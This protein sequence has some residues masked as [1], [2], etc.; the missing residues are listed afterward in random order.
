MPPR[1]KRLTPD[2]MSQQL[3]MPSDNS[4]TDNAI[5]ASPDRLAKPGPPVTQEAKEANQDDWK[6]AA[7]VKDP[8][9][10]EA[11]KHIEN[12]ENMQ[13]IIDDLL[14]QYD[15]Y[16]LHEPCTPP[17]PEVWGNGIAWADKTRQCWLEFIGSIIEAQNIIEDQD[18][19]AR[20]RLRELLK[21]CVEYACSQEGMLDDLLFFEFAPGPYFVQ[22]EGDIPPEQTPD[23]DRTRY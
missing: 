2:T 7:R 4:L 17:N 12:A 14:I 19:E 6:Q 11:L 23:F 16:E 18:P 21:E 22:D 1:M 13:R 9:I 10:E 15:L 20:V 8:E 5:G 3:A